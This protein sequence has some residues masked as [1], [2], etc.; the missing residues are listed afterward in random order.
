MKG[1]LISAAIA[2]LVSAGPAFAVEKDK[3]KKQES[4]AA[5]SQAADAGR[6]GL[7]EWPVSKEE[8]DWSSGAPASASSGESSGSA[9]TGTPRTGGETSDRTPEKKTETPPAQEDTEGG[10]TS[11]RTPEK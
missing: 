8:A 11:D 9:G 3:T 2:A 6:G 7:K 1:L 10:K 4:S 5:S